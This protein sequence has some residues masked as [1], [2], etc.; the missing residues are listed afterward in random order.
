MYLE[1]FSYILFV[2]SIQYVSVTSVIHFSGFPCFLFFS[3]LF[4]TS[5]LSFTC[6]F[7]LHAQ[8]TDDC[9]MP[10]VNMD[11]LDCT[12]CVEDCIEEEMIEEA[13]GELI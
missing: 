3:F 5:I 8:V 11:C 2:I 12:K 10:E 9:A 4:L 1:D 6:P 13:E 7:S